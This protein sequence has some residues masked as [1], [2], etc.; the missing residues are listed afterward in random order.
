LDHKPT[1]LHD[2]ELFIAVAGSISI[3]PNVRKRKDWK[4]VKH[5]DISN[6]VS[7]RL[8]SLG[9]HQATHASFVG[10]PVC[11]RWAFELPSINLDWEAT[12]AGSSL[13]LQ[14]AKS[15]RTCA[16]IGGE[17]LLYSFNS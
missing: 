9:L 15:I 14:T 13:G 11:I 12:A 4:V 3:I 5:T 16:T 2:E 7:R 8:Y 6:T 10:F 1:G 17:Q